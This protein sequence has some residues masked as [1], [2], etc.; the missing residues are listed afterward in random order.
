LE[1][2]KTMHTPEDWQRLVF[3]AYALVESEFLEKS[4][5]EAKVRSTF[6]SLMMRSHPIAKREL[7]AAGYD[8]E[9]VNQ[10]PAGQVVAIYAA[11][12]HREMMD[13]VV[14]WM[15]VPYAEGHARLNSLE[16]EL[17]RDG[18]MSNGP[19]LFGDRDPL[20]LNHKLT[21]SYAQFNEAANRQPRLVAAMSVVEAIRLHLSSHPGAFP[22]D[23]KEITEVTIPNDPGT[24]KP[25]LYRIVNGEAELL[26]PPTMPGVEHSGRRFRLKQR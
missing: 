25:F 2:E 7:I 17:V 10:M 18:Y 19:D 13:Q 26:A 3:D 8:T 4:I 12:C 15:S 23:L 5:D 22:M 24:G 9:K 21:F 20:L 14:K 6:D 16:D 11:R 1:G